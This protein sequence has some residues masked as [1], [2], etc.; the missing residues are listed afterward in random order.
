[1]RSSDDILRELLFKINND[2]SSGLIY[3]HSRINYNTTKTLDAIAFL[4]ALIDLLKEKGILSIDDLED[5]KKQVAE[6]VVRMFAE[7]GISVIYQEPEYDKYNYQHEVDVDCRSLHSVCR[8]V[9]CKLPHALSRQD[10]EEGIIRWEYGRPYLIA[11]DKDG[12]CVHLDRETLMC[13]VHAH[14]PSACRGFDCRNTERWQIWQDFDRKKL[15]LRFDEQINET[16][17]RLYT[18]PKY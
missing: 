17:V 6:N 11:H 14:R 7:S 13:L 16:I 10:V 5:R 18:Y 9:C 8:S 1:V 4:Y 15:N 12:Y 2:L 3:A